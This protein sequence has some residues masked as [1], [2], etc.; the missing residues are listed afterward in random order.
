MFRCASISWFQV[1]TKWVSESVSD[2]FC[3]A[4][5]S[6][7]SMISHEI[8]LWDI[9]WYK[10]YNDTTNTA[11]SID[12]SKT[13]VSVTR[14]S[15]YLARTDFVVRITKKT[16]YSFITSQQQSILLM[17]AFCSSRIVHKCYENWDWCETHSPKARGGGL[18]SEYGKQILSGVSMS[19]ESISIMMSNIFVI[20]NPRIVTKLQI[21]LDGS[22]S[23]SLCVSGQRE[24]VLYMQLSPHPSDN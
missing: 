23:S 6:A 3:G 21:R 1:V 19:S 13:S 2:I 9:L 7:M 10:W 20:R 17:P 4:S 16:F 18:C 5:I 24:W 8:S 12:T 14:L 22:S 11:N 15:S